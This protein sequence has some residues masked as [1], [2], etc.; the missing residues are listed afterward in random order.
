[1]KLDETLAA[2]VSAQGHYEVQDRSIQRFYMMGTQSLNWKPMSK[3]SS[4]DTITGGD[5]Q[6]NDSHYIE[7]LAV[8]AALA[9][10]NLEDHI[11]AKEKNDRQPRYLYRAIEDTEQLEFQDFVGL[12]RA[13]E[14]ARKAGMLLVFSILCNVEDYDFVA[15]VQAGKQKEFATYTNISPQQIEELKKYFR[16][17]HAYVDEQ[18]GL[19]E[20]WLRQLHRS[21]GG[22]DKFLF[23]AT[24]FTPNDA[25]MFRK[26]TF[27]KG[28]YRDAGV[29]Q[30]KGFSTGLFSNQFDSFKDEIV[31][32][33]KR[34]VP[35]LDNRGEQ[36][37]KM[38]YDALM[39]LY[40]FS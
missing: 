6:K 14:F 9:F 25:K 20:G 30:G 34:G 13:E 16:L 15:S 19:Q 7:L 11:L 12:D 5:K 32:V 3:L 35:A 2:N 37:Y 8:S 38:V 28:L 18:G 33:H 27:N 40:K 17:L 24:I 26:I 39:S 21:A 23:G 31:K 1:M 10:V 36:L 29:A 4:Q 22:G